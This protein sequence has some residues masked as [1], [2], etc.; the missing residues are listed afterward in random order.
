MNPANVEAVERGVQ[1]AAAYEVECLIPLN[2][3]MPVNVRWR[4]EKKEVQDRKV[5]MW[6]ARN[7][8]DMK[9]H[10]SKCGSCSV[11]ETDNAALNR[12]ASRSVLERKI[13]TAENSLFRFYRIIAVSYHKVMITHHLPQHHAGR[14]FIMQEAHAIYMAMR[15][16]Q[17]SLLQHRTLNSLINAANIA[18]EDIATA[19]GMPGR[20]Y[21]IAYYFF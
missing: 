7:H 21:D 3:R 18:A 20:Y 15:H 1:E 13:E 10:V 4:A 2:G 5:Y 17:A 11:F 12:R 14:I 8:Q 19:M 16:F 9:A 6:H